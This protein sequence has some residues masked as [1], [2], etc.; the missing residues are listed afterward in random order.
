MKA[1]IVGPAFALPGGIQYVG[2]LM[3]A[4]FGAAYGQAFELDI[5]SLHDGVRP[6]FTGPVRH[7]SGAG[8]RRGQFIKALRQA[9]RRRPQVVLLNHVNLLPL[10]SLAAIGLRTGPTAVVMHGVEAWKPLSRVRRIGLG[11]VTSVIYVSA[12]TQRK[13]T[14][15]NPALRSIPGCVCHHGLLPEPSVAESSGDG[16]AAA[17]FVLMIGRMSAGE[18]YKGYEELI[19]AWPEVR[20]HRPE[21]ELVLVGDGDDRPR[22]ETLAGSGLGVRFLGQ[23]N[24]VERDRLLKACAAF[25]LPSRGEGFGLVYLEAMKA[26]K[27]V[28]AGLH[29]AGAEVMIDGVTG[30]AVDAGDLESVIRAVVEV[31]SDVG[32]AMGSAGQKRYSE[33]FTFAAYTK[34]FHRAIEEIIHPRHSNAAG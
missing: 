32:A 1:L 29:D 24:D 28:I 17:P 6:E 15:A 8:G 12:V 33:M 21:L 18:Q 30:R 34:R 19:R 4:A 23:V 31:C 14:D 26:G 27:P 11:R 9:L 22:L 25:A 10:L 7:W 16:L 3:A 2:Q 5:V 13:A 20:R